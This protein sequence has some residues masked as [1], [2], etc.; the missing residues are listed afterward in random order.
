M[1]DDTLAS[2]LTP[3]KDPLYQQTVNAFESFESTP[4]MVE[5]KKQLASDRE[6]EQNAYGQEQKA[7]N[8][9]QQYLQQ[10]VDTAK[11][12]Q[13]QLQDVP[14]LADQASYF[15]TTTP[16]MMILAGIGGILGKS[17]AVV[18]L[19]AMNGMLEGQ[20]KGNQAQYDM[21]KQK[22]DDAIAKIQQ[23]Y[24][25]AVAVTDMMIKA[26]E[27]Q[28]DSAKIGQQAAAAAIGADDKLIDKMRGDFKDIYKSV[29]AAHERQAARA[30]Q[31]KLTQ[32]GYKAL[33][34]KSKA[35]EAAITS[36][37]KYDERAQAV[38]T[39]WKALKDQMKK[40]PGLKAAIDAAAIKGDLSGLNAV[41]YK[42]VADFQR[43]A[44]QLAPAAMVEINRGLSAG[45]IRAAGVKFAS[46]E[47]DSLP[48]LKAG[49]NQAESAVAQLEK[50]SQEI[51]QTAAEKQ[52]SLSREVADFQK[53][54][55]YAPLQSDISLPS[56]PAS[57]GGVKNWEDL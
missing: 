7:A 1:P 9:R 19:N 10:N 15:K 27:G 16:Q 6:R 24:N 11:Q 30:G 54:N 14:P 17:S 51:Y 39:A 53:G 13:K 5:A 22:H 2:A 43:A 44:A 29:L 20:M 3:N 36:A 38:I 45:A 8:T 52:S 55:V 47:L 41:Q 18:A 34:D 21:A 49:I 31:D 4:E 42:A 32:L 40:D 57:G 46:M 33:V 26:T 28:V 37:K 50:D 35:T 12:Y 23:E 56:A 25:T 48:G